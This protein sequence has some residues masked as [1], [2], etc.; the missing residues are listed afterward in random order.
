MGDLLVK[1]KWPKGKVGML[2]V[3]RRGK[4][5][6]RGGEE[7]LRMRRIVGDLEL[8]LGAAIAGCF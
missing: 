7:G 5:G 6:R 3:C 4:K 2:E 8:N 1:V